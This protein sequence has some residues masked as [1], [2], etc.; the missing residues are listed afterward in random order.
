[1]SSKVLTGFPAEGLRTSRRF[2]TSHNGDGK[3]VFVV[4]DV[5]DHHR[6]LAQGKGVGNIIYSTAENPV[7]MNDDKDLK[8]A[9]DHEVCM[10]RR[11]AWS[12]MVPRFNEY[13]IRRLLIP[14]SVP[15]V[16][17]QSMSPTVASFAWSTS[18]PTANHPCTAPCR[19]TTASWSRASS[20]LR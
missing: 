20:S 4:D 9:R 8:Y 19:S 5:G 14:C 17:P 12:R 6:V 7:D 3:G 15:L 2:I 18:L 16:S 10:Y 1:M 11:G 13:H